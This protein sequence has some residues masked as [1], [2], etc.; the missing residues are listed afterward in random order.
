M[1]GYVLESSKKAFSAF[2]LDTSTD[3][4]A[5]G[6]MTLETTICI[7]MKTFDRNAFFVQIGVCLLSLS[8][9]STTLASPGK[10]L[11]KRPWCIGSSS[12]SFCPWASVGPGVLQS[13]GVR[14]VFGV[15]WSG[16]AGEFLFSVFLNEFSKVPKHPSWV[17]YFCL[18]LEFQCFFRLFLVMLGGMINSSWSFWPRY[19]QKNQVTKVQ[20]PIAGF[21]DGFVFTFCCQ[22]IGLVLRSGDFLLSFLRVCYC[23]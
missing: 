22:T 13:D 15:D 17:V 12:M 2:Q 7:K 18:W 1:F 16:F 11:A 14:G 23:F 4:A 19:S 6:K 20:Y 3:E 8:C 5:Q 21:I 9:R 10:S